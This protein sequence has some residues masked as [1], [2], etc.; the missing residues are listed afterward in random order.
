MTLWREKMNLQEI[1]NE[2]E[3]S[4]NII[5]KDFFGTTALPQY[6][7]NVPLED[8]LNLIGDT[9]EKVVLEIGCGS[10]HSMLYLAERGV[11][12]L[13]GMDISESQVNTATELLSENGFQATMMKSSME[14]DPGIPH[15]Y[16]DVVF[17]IYALGW[18]LNL[19]ETL[20]NVSNYLKNDGI[21]IFSWDHP[22]MHCVDEVDG[23]LIFSGNYNEEDVFSFEKSNSKL[24]LI[25][26]KFSTYIN[27]LFEE[28]FMVEKI[29]EEVCA[30]NISKEFSSA[31]YSTVKSSHFPMSFVIK[32]RKIKK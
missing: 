23:E 24:T 18:T 20:R 29:V 1:I 9:S 31:Y 25:N 14:N 4:W 16:F 15:N 3:K 32:A 2:N 26:R 11:Q 27:T 10:G 30:D 21:F 8:E 13:W 6:G 5:S 19:R 12:E 17:S 22:F 28:G 7:C